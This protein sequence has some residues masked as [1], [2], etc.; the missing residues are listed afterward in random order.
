MTLSAA[1]VAKAR[2]LDAWDET[3]GLRALRF[4]LPRS[5]ACAHERPGQVV[6]LRTADQ[7]ARE[8]VAVLSHRLETLE[9][10]LDNGRILGGN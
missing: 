6:K 10:A 9:H 3:P 7:L 5:L 4:E 1:P 8:L 2:V